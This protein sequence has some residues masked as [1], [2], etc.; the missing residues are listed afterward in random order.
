VTFFRTISGTTLRAITG[1]AA[2][3]VL[4]GAKK[5]PEPSCPQV[6]EYAVVVSTVEV[7]GSFAAGREHIRLGGVIDVSKPALEGLLARAPVTTAAGVPDRY[8]RSVAQVFAGGTWIQEALVRA[9]EARVAPDG[10]S[11]PCA[12]RLLAAE[13]RARSSKIGG[14]GGGSFRVW[15]EGALRGQMRAHAGTFQIFEGR[16]LDSAVV[17]GRGY[18]NFGSDR[19]IDTTVTIAPADMKAFRKARLDVRKLK[20]AHVR[21]RGWLEIYNGPN[22]VLARPEAIEILEPSPEIQTARKN[23]AAASKQK[24]K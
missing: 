16:V 17:K 20:G 12:V 18:L 5:L 4:T 24:K 1:C 10:V 7:D 2:I 21:V 13:E 9:G 8:G 14:W 6:G 22:I 23:R 11:A 19:K 3:F 15:S